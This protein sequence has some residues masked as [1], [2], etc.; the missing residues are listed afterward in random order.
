MSHQDGDARS[1]VT[2]VGLRRRIRKR[3][4]LIEL[5]VVIA[6]I[7]I[8]ASLLLPALNQAREAARRT[9]CMTNMRTLGQTLHIY[10]S[11]YDGVV[12][13]TFGPA[14][15]TSDW[16]G[17]MRWEANAVT[18]LYTYLPSPHVYQCPS[19]VNSNFMQRVQMRMAP[20]AYDGAPRSH[21]ANHPVIHSS[22]YGWASA[23]PD[24]GYSYS[25][26]EHGMQSNFGG[27]GYN[28]TGS[29]DF[30]PNEEGSGTAFWRLDRI[31]RMIWI[32]GHAGGSWAWASS[33]RGNAALPDYLAAGRVVPGSDIPHSEW[34]DYGTN[35]I[36]LVTKRH[37]G[38]YNAAYYDGSVRSIKWGDSTSEDWYGN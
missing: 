24:V 8:L 14:P 27:Q 7:A 3:F 29:A 32:A 30:F 5:L 12:L 11:D 38:S 4:T 15:A 35:G 18:F 20:A 21:A 19:H 23:G 1:T 28:A 36:N 13:P 34:P 17:N 22:L 6:I 37:S 31:P 33:F 16:W 10:A 26:N 2:R 9:M 25:V